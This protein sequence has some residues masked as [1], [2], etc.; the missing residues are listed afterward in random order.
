VNEDDWQRLQEVTEHFRTW[1]ETQPVEIRSGEWECDYEEWGAIYQR[2]ERF[3]QRTSVE[4]WSDDA[5]SLVLYLIARDNEFQRLVRLVAED[6]MRLLFVARASLA[7][8]DRD[9]R[10]Q[11]AVE[12]GRIKR[13]NELRH[14]AED[15][16]LLLVQDKDEYVR[17]QALMALA[18]LRSSHVG[19]LA[20]EIWNIEHESQQWARMAVLW[21][22]KH[23]RSPLFEAFLTEAESDPR[24][25]LAE[26][27]RKMRQKKPVP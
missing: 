17:R 6:P 10:W 25:Y 15:L 3:I 5:T 9:A 4:Q 2:F 27:A 26:Y 14:T 24:P 18:N 19:R 20:T 16:L 12:L 21:S 7:H 8:S 22:L 13:R 23:V 11:I 1:A